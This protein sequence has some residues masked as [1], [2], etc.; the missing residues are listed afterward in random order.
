MMHGKAAFLV[1][2]AAEARIARRSG[3]PVAIG[4]GTTAGAALAARR[5]IDAGATGLISFGLAGGLDPALPAGTLIVA[6]IVLAN[7]HALRSDPVLSARLGGSTGHCCL[8]LDHIATTPAEKH[9]LGQESGAAVADMESGAVALAA[10]AVG[11]PFA[12]LRA[13]CDTAEQELPPA[14]LVALDP[15]GNIAWARIAR[16]VLMNPGQI[17]ALSGLARDAAAA[18][19]ACE[20]RIAAIRLVGDVI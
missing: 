5:L 9:R 6:D 20:S 13:I 2:F 18:R 15:A 17:R 14:A 16:S 3:W 7:G 11:L 10:K 1:G 19:A 12:V 8:A 4:G